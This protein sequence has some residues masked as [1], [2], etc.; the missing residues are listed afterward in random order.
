MDYIANRSDQ[1][2]EMLKAIGVSCIEEL[3]SSIPQ[4]LIHPRP[5]SED[6]LSESEGIAAME[7][8]SHENSYLGFESYLGAGAYAH[9]I[10]AIVST[11]TSRSEFLT[12]YTPYQAEASQGLLQALFEYQSTI[13]AL[14]KMDA[15]N[16]SVYDA[17]SACAEACLMGIRADAQE[18]K[19]IAISEGVNP[20]YLKVVEQYISGLGIELELVP[21]K[22]G[23]TDWSALKKPVACVLYQ[24]PNFFGTIEMAPTDVPYPKICCGNPISFALLAPP[25]DQEVDICVGDLQ[26]L[27]LPLSFGGPYAGFITCKEPWI[28]RLP[29]R[30]VGKTVDAEGKDGYVLTLQAREQH[31]RREKAT[32]NIC[33]NQTLAAIAFLVT[34]L[35]YGPKGLKKLA[36]TN[37]QRAHYLHSKL[38]TIPGIHVSNGTDFFNEFVVRFDQPIEKVLKHFRNQK[39][40]PGLPLHRFFPER[41]QELLVAV[42]ELKDLEQL[43]RYIR[44]AEEIA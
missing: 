23:K 43:T 39:I 10:P 3:L 5:S 42:T 7:R 2:E 35:W 14:T 41:T 32:S 31:I 19:C 36:L 13:T 1:N 6:G 37:Y 24:S 25:G 17:A 33:T 21:L 11:I 16:A 22:E 44:L 38:K 40:D 34:T 4:E 18:T 29:G 27:G 20:L 8:L 30:I 28:R 26:P 15:S 12:S 9:Y